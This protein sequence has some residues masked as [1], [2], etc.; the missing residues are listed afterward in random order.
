MNELSKIGFEHQV[1]YTSPDEKIIETQKVHNILLNESIT[2]FLGTVFALTTKDSNNYNYKCY[3]RFF[4]LFMESDYIP[5]PTDSVAGGALELYEADYN[6]TLFAIKSVANANTTQLFNSNN[7]AM[8][9]DNSSVIIES[10]TFTFPI[11]KTLTGVIL[12]HDY[13]NVFNS[14]SYYNNS[15]ISSITLNNLKLTRLLSVAKFN[16]PMQVMRDGKIKTK[17]NFIL[18][19]S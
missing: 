4:Y 7:V 13:N 11:S 8:G 1:V 2:N 19:P 14:L 17:S 3:R 10:G 15:S 16:T 12:L 5:L 6:N 9:K 18:I